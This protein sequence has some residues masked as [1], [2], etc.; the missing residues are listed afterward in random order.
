MT[1]FF[2]LDMTVDAHRAVKKLVVLTYERKIK[3]FGKCLYLGKKYNRKA[4]F[5]QVYL[6]FIIV[7]HEFVYPCLK[8][9]V[10]QLAITILTSHF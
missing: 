1:G 5:H 7:W 10:D 4:I 3:H 2:I 6:T 9:I 8:K